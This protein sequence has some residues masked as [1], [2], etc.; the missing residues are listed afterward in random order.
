MYIYTYIYLDFTL[1]ISISYTS[2]RSAGSD[3]GFG[4]RARPA[5]SDGCGCALGRGDG[6]G[7]RS[8][9]AAASVGGLGRLRR[10]TQRVLPAFKPDIL[11][12]WS[13]LTNQRAR[14]VTQ[15]G[16]QTNYVPQAPH[17]GHS[18][19]TKLDPPQDGKY[20]IF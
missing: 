2:T 4:R 14:N 8:R 10:R 12:T 20:L 13:I 15:N 18:W 7:G 11:I 5:G 16:A 6:C 17:M 3:G 1:L 9:S 19:G